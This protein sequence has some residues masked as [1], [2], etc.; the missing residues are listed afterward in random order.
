MGSVGATTSPQITNAIAMK[1][2]RGEHCKVR[3]KD[4]HLLPLP[5]PTPRE[6]AHGGGEGA[7]RYGNRSG[8]PISIPNC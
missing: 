8:A 5:S 7:D 3:G 6:L 2:D 1:A 4:T